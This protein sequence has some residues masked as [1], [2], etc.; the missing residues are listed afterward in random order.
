MQFANGLEFYCTTPANAVLP[1][2]FLDTDTP[3]LQSLEKFC[4]FRVQNERNVGVAFI[5]VC[6]LHSLQRP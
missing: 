5:V 2:N 1:L 4:V 3:F 6:F